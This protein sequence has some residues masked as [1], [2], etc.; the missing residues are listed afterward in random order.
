[1]TTTMADAFERAGWKKPEDA[2]ERLRSM[3]RD[4]IVAGKA[5]RDRS[6]GQFVRALQDANDAQLV[7][8]LFEK[9]HDDVIQKLFNE[10]RYEVRAEVAQ[11]NGS[12]EA[13]GRL[14][15]GLSSD[16]SSLPPAVV[17]RAK[18]GVPQG[19]SPL[20]LST[21]PDA[22]YEATLPLPQGQNVSASSSAPEGEAGTKA[23]VPQGH[24]GNVLASPPMSEARR[25]AMAEA[26]RGSGFHIIEQNGTRTLI[27]DVGV[28][29][30]PQLRKQ[31]A[32]GLYANA[33]QYR[34]VQLIEG[35]TGGFVPDTHLVK[36][37]CSRDEILDFVKTAREM[38]EGPALVIP[39]ELAGA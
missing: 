14:P 32:R 33:L 35:K 31:S 11:R 3:M 21:A 37:I 34:V 1:M 25:K 26:W 5:L 24:D 27:D 19:H 15:E 20:A 7:W 9:Q 17:E 39:R 28:K 10:L 8:W 18:N 36:D 12:G 38:I 2:H 13:N 22:G 16:A 23:S 4:A 30:L 6:C 29:R